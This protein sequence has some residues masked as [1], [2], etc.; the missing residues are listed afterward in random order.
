M[1]I[2]IFLHFHGSHNR[3]SDTG[4][5]Y[6]KFSILLGNNS[7]SHNSQDIQSCFCHAS[8]KRQCTLKHLPFWQETQKHADSQ[9]YQ[10][11][12][13]SEPFLHMLYQSHTVS[14]PGSLIYHWQ[15][16]SLLH[17]KLRVHFPRCYYWHS[18]RWA[19]YYPL[20]L[21]KKALMKE[22]HTWITYSYALCLCSRGDGGYKL[23]GGDAWCCC[24]SPWGGSQDSSW[25]VSAR[26]VSIKLSG[27]P[28]T[29]SWGTMVLFRH[30]GQG[31]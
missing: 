23:R 12:Q 19:T 29:P 22:S 28:A 26:L 5:G 24:T 21:K 3:H 20:W 1:S 2:S 8:H 4:G 18:N 13:I 9:G 15:T 31:K 30:M 7:A 17:Q 11:K 6:L 25:I 27:K 16:N 14:M 10:N